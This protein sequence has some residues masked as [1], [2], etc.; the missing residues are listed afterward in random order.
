MFILFGTSIL[1][2]FYVWVLVK[3]Q[4]CN[5][6]ISYLCKYLG[7]YQDLVSYIAL[8]AKV[9]FLSRQTNRCLVIVVRA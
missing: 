1:K 4:F 2:I 8:M 3:I 6:G 9:I 5:L 7:K